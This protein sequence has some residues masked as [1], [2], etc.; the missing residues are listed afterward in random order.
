M[1][2]F[3]AVPLLASDYAFSAIFIP[4]LI[5][6]LAAL[7]LNILTGY[8][9]QLSLG[10]AAFMAVGAFASYNFMLRVPGIPILLA[11]VLGGISA[12]MVGIA[13]GLPSLRIRG[14]YLAAATLATQFLWSGV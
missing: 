6:S 5:F 4:F 12:A 1:R 11:F 8:A 2:R 13:F 9:G 14:F 7:G 10:S 3:F